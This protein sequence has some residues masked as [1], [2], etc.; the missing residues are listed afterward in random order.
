MK[1]V[2]TA[3]LTAGPAAAAM[4]LAERAV[5]ALERIADG[6]T[7]A[8]ARA[9]ELDVPRDYRYERRDSL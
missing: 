1:N 2:L 8:N 5:T 6:L 7:E 3:A 4:Q 9:A